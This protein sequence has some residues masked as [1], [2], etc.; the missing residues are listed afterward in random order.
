MYKKIPLLIFIVWVWKG[1][2]IPHSIP[3]HMLMALV[4][5]GLDGYCL[6]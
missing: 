2:D 5:V 6:I 1:E 3:D 4:L